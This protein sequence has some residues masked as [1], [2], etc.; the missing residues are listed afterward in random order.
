MGKQ[1]RLTGKGEKSA[2][3]QL[4]PH[5]ANLFRTSKSYL[6]HKI[7]MIEYRSTLFTLVT[8]VSFQNCKLVLMWVESIFVVHKILSLPPS[9][10]EAAKMRYVTFKGGHMR[11]HV[12]S[13]EH[14]WMHSTT[15]LAVTAQRCARR[16]VG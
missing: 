3:G 9:F 5:R 4:Y 11:H 10:L 15:I 16:L 1:K 13:A 7:Y 14:T 2:D 12:Q 6:L 8:D